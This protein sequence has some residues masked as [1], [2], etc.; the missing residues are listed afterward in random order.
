MKQQTQSQQKEKLKKPWLENNF[1]LLNK[2]TGEVLTFAKLDFWKKGQSKII[3]GKTDGT[4]L[5]YS[6]SVYQVIKKTSDKPK[7]EI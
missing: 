3:V 7:K 2:E 1:A 4:K 6:T 5:F